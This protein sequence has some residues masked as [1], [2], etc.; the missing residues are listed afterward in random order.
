L[1]DAAGGK[2]ERVSIVKINAITVPKDKQERFEERFRGRAGAVDKTPGFE[3]FELL[4]PVEGTDQYLVYTRWA[5]E[6]A[7]QEWA[8]GQDF[9]RAHQGGGDELAPAAAPS[10]HLWSYEVLETAGPAGS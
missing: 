9:A 8:G 1:T 2:G 4:R 5:S 10:S 6:E 7:Y 3:W